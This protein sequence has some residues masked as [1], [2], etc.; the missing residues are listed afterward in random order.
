VPAPCDAYCLLHF[1]LVAGI[2]VVAAG[3]EEMVLH[4]EDP[5]PTVLRLTLALG[6]VLYLGGTDLAWWRATG[7][8]LV[9]A[10]TVVGLPLAVGIAVVET[11][12]LGEIGVVVGGLGLSSCWSSPAVSGAGRRQGPAHRPTGGQRESRVGRWSSHV[13]VVVSVRHGG[14]AL[15]SA[16]H[17]TPAHAA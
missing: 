3:I 4:P 12:A 9:V 6:I 10:R 5:L 11:A 16:D 2:V 14:E 8:V 17:A 7:Q 13:F 15:P 1:V